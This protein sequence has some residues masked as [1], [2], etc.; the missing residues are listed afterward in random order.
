[1]NNVVIKYVAQHISPSLLT[2]TPCSERHQ[3]TK[4]SMCSEPALVALAPRALN[5]HYISLTLTSTQHGGT[6]AWYSAHRHERTERGLYVPV[7]RFSLHLPP[8]SPL[9]HTC[10]H[11]SR[12]PFRHY[13]PCSSHSAAHHSVLKEPGE[14]KQR[15]GGS[16]CHGSVGSALWQRLSRRTQ[17][18]QGASLQS[19]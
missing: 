18:C 10:C 5:P 3:T 11:C 8:F 13:E 17:G 1:M 16:H 19:R 14:D 7:I 6:A 4:R 15:V 12:D 2:P 9:I